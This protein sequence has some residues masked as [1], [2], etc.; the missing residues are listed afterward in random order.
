MQ[1]RLRTVH[2]DAFT[3]CM[4]GAQPTPW[5]PTH[6]L[7]SA[8]RLL[9]PFLPLHV[10]GWR[11]LPRA[12]EHSSSKVGGSEQG[13]AHAA[14]CSGACVWASR[15]ARA[16]APTQQ[17]AP[18]RPR[19]QKRPPPRAPPRPATAGACAH[20]CLR[21]Q[22][23]ALG[24]QLYW[25]KHAA[26]HGKGAVDGLES[27]ANKR[28]T[29]VLSAAPP[30]MPGAQVSRRFS[31]RPPAPPASSFLP[32][33]ISRVRPLTCMPGRHFAIKQRSH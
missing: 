25:P 5:C 14:G 31:R 32:S 21:A 9:S 3:D 17:R 22:P 27:M 7:V 16:H 33:I 26:Q 11:R 20:G 1:E 15:S 4:H 2:D 24:G 12:A 18:R 8:A 29:A 30:A 28:S 23:E 13:S 19:P 10:S 6:T